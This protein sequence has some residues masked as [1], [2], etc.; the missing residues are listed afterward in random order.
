MERTRRS[1]AFPKLQS[2]PNLCR[3]TL[4]NTQRDLPLSMRALREVIS[5]FIRELQIQTSEVIFHFVSERK[6]IRL[7]KEFFNDP[8][9]TDCITFPLDSPTEQH[10]FHILGEAFICPKTACTYARQHKG[11]P[12]LELYRYIV[13][14]LLHLIGYD[15]IDPEERKSMK[16]KENTCLKKLQKSQLEEFLLRKKFLD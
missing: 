10:P 7:H 6:I 11:D 3:I 15:D 8:T 9:S 16:R 12:H 14:C 5:F 2:F 1:P 4:H 13:H